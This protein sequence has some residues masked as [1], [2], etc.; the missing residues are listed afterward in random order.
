MERVS[1]VRKLKICRVCRKKITG[2]GKFYCSNHCRYADHSNVVRKSYTPELKEIRRKAANTQWSARLPLR[3][4]KKLERELAKGVQ[5]GR[6]LSILRESRFCQN[7]E[8]EFEFIEGRGSSGIFCS[9]KCHL[10]WS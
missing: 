1:L 9:R 5:V 8:V 4:R 6:S 3:A 2:Q 10:D 7:C